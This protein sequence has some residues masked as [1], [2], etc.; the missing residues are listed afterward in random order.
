MGL[1]MYL[2]GEKFYW[3]DYEHPEN[4]LVEDGFSLESK[5]L[6]LAQ[7]R[8]HP[9]LHGYIVQTFANGVDECQ[10]IELSE[11]DLLKI[12]NA[13]ENNALPETEGFFFGTTTSADEQDTIEKIKKAL[14]WYS[15][16][17]RNVA[18]TIYYQASW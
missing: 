2:N 9:N 6:R 1:D 3:T 14:E 8:K 18:K 13:V 16:K 10:K 7:W 15:I 5:M 17:E 12:I 11:N 4:N